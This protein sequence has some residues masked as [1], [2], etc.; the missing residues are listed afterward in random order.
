MGCLMSSEKEERDEMSRE[1]GAKQAEELATDGLQL[2]FVTNS[3]DPAAITLGLW[4]SKKLSDRIYL[5]YDG[6]DNAQCCKRYV[7]PHAAITR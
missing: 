4:K 2:R 3:D 6:F 7:S 1:L 5:S